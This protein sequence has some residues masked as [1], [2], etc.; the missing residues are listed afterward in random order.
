[1][2]IANAGPRHGTKREQL[3]EVAKSLSPAISKVLLESRFEMQ[4]RIFRGSDGFTKWARIKSRSLAFTVSKVDCLVL[5]VQELQQVGHR[6][7]HPQ[8]ILRRQ[9]PGG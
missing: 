3:Q 8:R 1:M 9:P 7:L 6:S 5:T 4:M 2:V